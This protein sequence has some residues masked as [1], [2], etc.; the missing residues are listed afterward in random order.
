METLV[1]DNT[2][3]AI[4]LY[5]ALRAEDGNLFFSPYSISTALAMT[6]AGARGNTAQEMAQALH[7]S[8]PQA[9]LHAAFAELDAA[10][11]EI[12]AA[13][14]VELGVANSLWP[15][16]GY[17]FLDAY[18]ALVEQHYGVSITP[19]D[20]EQAAES[21]R[22]AINAWVEDKTRSKIENLIPPGILDTL[23]RLVLV[24]AIYFKGMWETQFKAEKTIAAPFR[25]S[26]GQSVQARLMTQ[27]QEFRHAAFDDLQV[28]E[29]PYVGNELAMIVLLPRAGAVLEDLEPNLSAENLAHWTSRLRFTKVEVF[30]PKFKMTA[31]FRLDQTLAA[32]GI[33]DAFDELEADFS[34]MDGQPHWLYIKAVLHKAFVEVNEEGTEAAAATAVVMGVRGMPSPPVV[35]RAD[36]PFLFLI[37][38]KRNG[39]VLFMG[40]VVEPSENGEEK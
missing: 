22:N 36:H 9:D 10:L 1:Q 20:Y 34:G 37:Q 2:R 15:Q 8:L 29:L 27:K 12:Q 17:P 21:A 14:N 18:L 33:T 28:L 25:V 4:D 19:V 5:H 24:N 35:F 16:Q 11:T 6:Y 31:M 3:F 30:L 38:D 13:G 26:P 7:F 23:T 40:R 32:M 39:S